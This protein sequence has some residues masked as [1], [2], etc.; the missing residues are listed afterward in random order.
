MMYYSFEVL[1]AFP[2][3]KISFRG[4][5][6][7]RRPKFG[8]ES[9]ASLALDRPQARRVVPFCGNNFAVED[10]VFLD[11]ETIFD[12]LKVSAQFCMVGIVGR[13]CPI[14]VDFRY[15]QSIDGILTVHSCPRISIPV[16]YSTEV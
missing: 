4:K 12:V 5:P 15:G 11:V 6:S 1:Q 13:P 14:A 8:F 2:V 3:R 9:P 10:A 7:A 16:P